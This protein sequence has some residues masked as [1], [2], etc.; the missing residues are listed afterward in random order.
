M[1]TRTG[2]AAA[3]LGAPEPRRRAARVSSSLLGFALLAGVAVVAVACAAPRGPAGGAAFREPPAAATER[4]G[5]TE[6][7]PPL[8]APD[9]LLVDTEGRPFR[10][11][12]ER[13]RWVLLFF[14]YTSCPDVCPTT[15]GNLRQALG[16]LGRNGE[17][18]RV[19]MVTVDPERDTPE[20]LAAYLGSAAGGDGRFLGLGGARGSL[21]A[22]WADYGVFV[23]REV[24]EGATGYSVSHTAS[25]YLI[26]PRGRLV[27]TYPFGLSA[28]AIAADLRRRL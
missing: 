10:L 12:E 23:E 11:S 13:G 2:R 15:L 9:F 19:V 26:D 7:E 21:E 22:V 17:R 27:A 24:E 28:R 16:L 1:T 4:L 5:S 14:G 6:F 25:V 8:S 18:V 3:R 20:R